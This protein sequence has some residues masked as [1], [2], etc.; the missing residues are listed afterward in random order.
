[1]KFQHPH[2]THN[3]I[4]ITYTHI[5]TSS[6]NLMRITSLHTRLS[7]LQISPQNFH[8]YI[9][10]DPTLKLY[11]P[12]YKSTFSIHS[13]QTKKSP[14]NSLQKR[15]QNHPATYPNNLTKSSVKECL[16]FSLRL[17]STLSLDSPSPL[18]IQKHQS[19]L[20]S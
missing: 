10:T 18:H 19:T 8:S 3:T 11:I 1:M 14:L 5:H 7:L 12:S 17:E 20:R 16:S 13:S 15:L 2:H 6:P 9:R 4:Y